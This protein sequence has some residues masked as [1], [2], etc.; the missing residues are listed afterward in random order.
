MNPR[1]WLML[2]AGLVAGVLLGAAAVGS[3]SFGRFTL[4]LCPVPGASTSPPSV[5]RGL[6]EGPWPAR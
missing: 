1:A 3:G 4:Q 2:A 5:E 6:P